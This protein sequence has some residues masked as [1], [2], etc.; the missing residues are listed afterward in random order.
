MN[1]NMM[2]LKVASDVFELFIFGPFLKVE[3]REIK[4]TERE[5]ENLI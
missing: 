2:I 3:W 4:T 5:K 1:V